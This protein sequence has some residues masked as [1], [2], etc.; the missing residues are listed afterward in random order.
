MGSR[1][2]LTFVVAE[3]LN[4]TVIIEARFLERIN[5]TLIFTGQCVS[6]LHCAVICSKS[7]R[8]G[9][10]TRTAIE[11]CVHVAGQSEADVFFSISTMDT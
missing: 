8:T 3:L 1:E 4:C 6:L 9:R 5:L 11:L 2:H 10:R 7:T